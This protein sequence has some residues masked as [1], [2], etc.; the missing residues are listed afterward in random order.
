MVASI[1]DHLM[2]ASGYDFDS[3]ECWP[4]T[5]EFFYRA[6]VASHRLLPALLQDCL[7]RRGE[8]LPPEPE[9][10]KLR[11]ELWASIEH[12][13][14]GHS[15][16][17]AAVRAGMFALTRDESWAPMDAIPLFESFY[18]GAGLPEASFRSAFLATWPGNGD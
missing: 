7:L 11:V 13:S 14:M 16:Q 17:A 5:R 3:S 18:L 4:A 8:V 10:A 1:A 6:L 12:D 15:P 9:L 2:S